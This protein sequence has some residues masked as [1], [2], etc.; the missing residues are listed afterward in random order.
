MEKF[1]IEFRIG[2]LIVDF[3][4]FLKE[5]DSLMLLDLYS[6]YNNNNKAAGSDV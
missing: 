3:W 2:F 1:N 4:E 6:T 5:T